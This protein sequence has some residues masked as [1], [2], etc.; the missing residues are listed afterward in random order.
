VTGSTS[1]IGK[2]VALRLASE[3]ADVVVTG[4]D[5]ERGRAVADA[6]RA[7]GGHAHFVAADLL[8]GE[9]AVTELVTAAESALGGPIDVLVNNAAYIHTG[10]TA[11]CDQRSIT[12]VLTVNVAVPI[13]LAARLAPAMAAAGGGAI[14]NVGAVA[15]TKGQAGIALYSASK[16]A[17]RTLTKAWAAEF[18]PSG[19]RVNEVSAGPTY[20]EGVEHVRHL[21]DE[22]CAS[23]PAGR[24]A[25][26]EQVAAA[27]AFL[28]SDD[29]SHIHG[30]TL[31]CDGGV[32]AT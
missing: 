29:A 8:D 14:V 24:P 19:V 10:P 1:G 18:G 12:D 5:A 7:D 11:G 30:A 22:F 9:S 28:V 4:R 6:I 21:L 25:T 20:T 3:G 16:G 26:P 17:L 32:A 23:T 27:V 13:L 2:A 15:T 31:D